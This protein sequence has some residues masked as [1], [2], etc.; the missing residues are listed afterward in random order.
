MTLVRKQEVTTTG[1][2]W[3]HGYTG[4]NVSEQVIFQPV[5]VS[6]STSVIRLHSPAPPRPLYSPPHLAADDL[7][8]V[9]EGKVLIAAVHQKHPSCA[10]MWILKP[11]SEAALQINACFHVRR[12]GG[13][14]G[15]GLILMAAAVLRCWDGWPIGCR[16]SV[17]ARSR[18]HVKRDLLNCVH[19]WHETS[20]SR[21][22]SKKL[23]CFWWD[24]KRIV[25]SE[26][27]QVTGCEML[28][29]RDFSSALVC[30]VLV[31][32]AFFFFFPRDSR[33]ILPFQSSSEY[34]NVFGC[35]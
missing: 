23:V 27:Q 14:G 25:T 35:F 11:I 21:P 6:V 9:N 19:Y 30:V 12:G 22:E 13:G 29:M 4:F 2:T 10:L 3:L 31:R 15:G 32:S 16:L 24:R 7:Q 1:E 28:K 5:T 8:S 20:R 34:E 26:R 17:A 18:R 33:L